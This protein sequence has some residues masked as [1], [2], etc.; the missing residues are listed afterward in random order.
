MLAESIAVII[1]PVHV[2]QVIM[3]YIL[4]ASVISQLYLNKTGRNLK[5]KNSLLIIILRDVLF[6]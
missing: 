1:L 4:N 2:C 5:I 6:L 3:L